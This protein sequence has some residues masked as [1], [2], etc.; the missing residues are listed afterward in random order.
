MEALF[1]IRVTKKPV[2]FSCLLLDT[3]RHFVT[4]RHGLGEGLVVQG[5]D[6]APVQ[7]HP[8]AGE[9]QLS[10]SDTQ[11]PAYLVISMFA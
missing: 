7:V 2:K 11:P 9:S 4:V 1:F 6:G 5:G 3:L 8:H 10:V